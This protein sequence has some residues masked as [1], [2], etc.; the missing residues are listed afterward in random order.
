MGLLLQGSD[1]LCAG[2]ESMSL[3]L[4]GSFKVALK[5]KALSLSVLKPIIKLA[6]LHTAVQVSLPQMTQIHAPH[7]MLPDQRGL[8][9]MTLCKVDL[10]KK[11]D[12]RVTPDRV[13]GEQS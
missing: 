3:N 9:V 7:T 13:P 5:S 11:A 8:Y 2:Y 6:S 4:S 12:A 1:K 10:R